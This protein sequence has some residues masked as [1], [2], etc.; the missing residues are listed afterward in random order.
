MQRLDGLRAAHVEDFVAALETLEVRQWEVHRLDA[1]A[2]GSV[3]HDGAA[4]GEIK[5]LGDAPS[6][7]RATDS[8]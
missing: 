8:A 4:S 2:G 6:A 1:G 5:Q 7:L 3:E